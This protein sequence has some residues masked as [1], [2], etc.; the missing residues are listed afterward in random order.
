MEILSAIVGIVALVGSLVSAGV[1]IHNDKKTQ[2]YNKELNQTVMEREDNSWQ[3]AVADRSSAGLSVAGLSQGAGSGGTVSHLQG[4]QGAGQLAN[5]LQGASSTAFGLANSAY[6]RK[7]QKQISTDE[8]E[9]KKQEL[10]VQK[11]K[12]R[13]EKLTSLIQARLDTLRWTKEAE[14][15]DEQISSSAAEGVRDQAIYEHNIEV[16]QRLGLPY[17][18]NPD[19]TS[20]LLGKG[21]EIISE[22]MDKLTSAI[23]D[24][25]NAPS[26]LINSAKEKVTKAR[27]KLKESID[28]KVHELSIKATTGGHSFSVSKEE[29]ARLDAREAEKKAK[30]EKK[31]RNLRETYK[32]YKRK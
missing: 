14:W 25:K 19:V 32:E 27:D 3:R 30:G 16:A 23:D 24:L 31:L 21:S 9:V 8:L 22:N 18:N 6:D 10:D 1:Q 7:L 11:D 15:L 29:Q 5:I 28:K 2:D 26:K 17:G 12:L 20:V 13:H 4:T